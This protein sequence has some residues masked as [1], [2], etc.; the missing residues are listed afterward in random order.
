MFLRSP[1]Y[2]RTHAGGHWD[3]PSGFYVALVEKDRIVLYVGVENN[4]ARLYHRVGFQG[5]AGGD[6][7]EGVETWLE[8]GFDRQRVE[9]GFW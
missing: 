1:R 5:L 8:L 7:V 6:E 9:L 3:A 4:A 2:S